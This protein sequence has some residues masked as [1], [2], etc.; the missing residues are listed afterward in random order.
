V[1]LSGVAATGDI[2]HTSARTRRKR[3]VSRPHACQRESTLHQHIAT[4]PCLPWITTL[5]LLL[6]IL[7]RW[8]ASLLG[9]VNRSYTCREAC[10]FLIC[11]PLQQAGYPSTIPCTQPIHV[12]NPAVHPFG[13]AC[14]CSTCYRPASF[15]RYSSLPVASRQA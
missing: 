14:P 13:R 4:G 12:R 9:R 11:T 1:C 7:P 15:R 10:V 5:T 8:D 3:P 2:G 6:R